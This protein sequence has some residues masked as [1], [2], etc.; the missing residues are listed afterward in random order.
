M[1]NLNT[2]NK[3]EL[4]NIKAEQTILG[5][6]ILNNDYL[7]RVI[8]ILKPEYFYEPIHKDIYEY[9]IKI[10]QR[11]GLSADSIT[12]KNFFDSNK[13]LNEL[14][15]SNYIDILINSAIGIV[16][17]LDYVKLIR[18]LFFKRKL[19][20]I[21][22]DIV[23]NVN[24]NITEKSCEDLIE[25]T[26]KKIYELDY[27]NEVN[28]KI[29]TLN[30]GVNISIQNSN[31]TH[32]R[33]TNIKGIP[34]GFIYL[35]KYLNGF[36]NSDLI[37]LGARPS[38]GKTTLALN[39][40]VNSARYFLEE[41]KK[42][43][44]NPKKV[45]FFSFE[46]PIDQIS[47]RILSMESGIGAEHII[48]GEIEHFANKITEASLRL[49]DLP[50][51]IDDTANITITEL[52]TRIRRLVKTQNIGIVYIDHMGRIGIK[53]SNN[54]SIYQKMTEISWGL[55]MIAKDFQIPVVAMSQLSRDS[56][57]L[58]NN[59]KKTYGF[60]I[61]EMPQL[62]QLRDS[63]SIE[64]DADVV[65][66]LHR[67]EYY[68]SRM[69]PEETLEEEGKKRFNQWLDAMEYYRDKAYIG[70]AKNRNGETPGIDIILQYNKHISKFED[71]KKADTTHD[72]Y[73]KN[74]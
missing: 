20:E 19:S 13:I 7:D 53:N 6:I 58:N 33:G 24:K 60:N 67:P 71:E 65:M 69:K 64:Q 73:I 32:K 3:I 63:G 45:A 46:M 16:D 57:N 54:M 21:G 34:T 72:P 1:N 23:V 47:T 74:Q 11:N 26:E 49:Q 17:I 48:K 38:M 37:I 8:E 30:E 5:T 18:D 42:N 50:F 28:K 31:E 51:L 59:K 35:D 29:Y 39:F 9:I 44:T 22:N 40:A 61:P 68:L 12:L 52:I 36:N 4:F 41:S 62:Q 27:S 15:G 55:K 70:I 2:Q 25:E 10:I 43:N 56:V 14:G 66:F